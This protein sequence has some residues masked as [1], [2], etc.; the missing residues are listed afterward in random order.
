MYIMIICILAMII[1]LIYGV[2]C[3]T[4]NFNYESQIK[5]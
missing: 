2:S 5:K 4:K 1:G 3:A